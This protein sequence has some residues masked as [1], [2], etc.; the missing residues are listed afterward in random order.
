M[1]IWVIKILITYFLLQLMSYDTKNYN[2]RPN[3]EHV[4][5]SNIAI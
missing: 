5:F 1:F 4:T 2:N 3:S